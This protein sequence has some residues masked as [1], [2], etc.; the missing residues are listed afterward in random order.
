MQELNHGKK[1]FYGCE[2]ERHGPHELHQS[3]YKMFNR[4]C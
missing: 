2:R 4:V 1:T 3:A